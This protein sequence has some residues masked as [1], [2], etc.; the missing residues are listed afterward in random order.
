MCYTVLA[1]VFITTLYIEFK[2]VFFFLY[3]KLFREKKKNKATNI[4]LE[5]YKPNSFKIPKIRSSTKQGISLLYLWFKPITAE[6]SGVNN[7]I[8]LT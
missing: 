2:P 1:N 4:F 8:S 6:L 3:M 7:S 5:I